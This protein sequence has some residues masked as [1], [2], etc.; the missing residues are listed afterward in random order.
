MGAAPPVLCPLDTAERPQG[1]ESACAGGDGGCG[2][3]GGGGDRAELQCKAADRPH[4]CREPAP[5][6]FSFT[7]LTRTAVAIAGG[8]VSAAGGSEFCGRGLLTW[9]WGGWRSGPLREQAESSPPPAL[10]PHLGSVT[11][12]PVSR[13][14]GSLEPRRRG[15]QAAPGLAA[16]CGSG[17]RHQEEV[18][19]GSRGGQGSGRPTCVGQPRTATQNMPAPDSASQLR[20][21]TCQLGM[22]A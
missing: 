2:G 14:R 9:A 12:G 19:H 6:G 3:Q 15:R 17:D 8:W 18:P 22:K 5:P 10:L 7:H 20:C 4:L 1:R 21:D 16:T 13:L 11:A